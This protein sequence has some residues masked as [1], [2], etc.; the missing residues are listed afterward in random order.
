MVENGSEEIL[1]GQR[2][3][4]AAIDLVFAGGRDMAFGGPAQGAVGPAFLGRRSRSVEQ[5]MDGAS[6]QARGGRSQQASGGGIGKADQP[7]AVDAADAVGHRIQKDL[8]L[9]G[10]FVGPAALPRS[11]QHLPQRC[12]HRLDG[13]DGLLVFAQQE[14]AVKLENRQHLVAHAYRHRPAR[15]HGMPQRGCNPWSGRSGF[16]IGNPNGTALQP[17]PAGKAH[18]AGQRYAHAL[19]DHGLGGSVRG[20]PGGAELENVFFA[21]DFPFES[22][23][24]ALRDAQRFENPHGGHI[25]RSVLSHDLA[26]HQLQGQAVL[27]PF[28][29]GDI[30]HAGTVP[31]VGCRPSAAG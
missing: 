24:P 17:D 9:P 30:A 16:Q 21:V 29:L 10:Q 13:G 8:L 22:Q 5:F 14:L 27:A 3:A 28:L 31:R 11:R 12:G 23:V 25:G 1:R 7:M 26:D 4:V 2:E 15:H 20:A 19:L 6:G 18:A